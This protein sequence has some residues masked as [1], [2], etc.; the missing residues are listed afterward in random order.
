MFS[1]EL[2]GDVGLLVHGARERKTKKKIEGQIDLLMRFLSPLSLSLGCDDMKKKKNVTK[3][4]DEG[5]RKRYRSCCS[6]DFYYY[7]RLP[8]I[9]SLHFLIFGFSRILAS[10]CGSITF[11]FDIEFKNECN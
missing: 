3:T 6:L 5:R 7:L 8:Y 4:K 2:F 9:F 10:L 11:K 1:V